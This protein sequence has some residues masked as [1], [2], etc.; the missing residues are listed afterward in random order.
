MRRS[1]SI[2]TISSKTTASDKS[3]KKKILLV[4][5]ESDITMSI[6]IALESYG[7]EVNSYNDPVMAL[8]CFR[9]HY[10]DL[11]MLDVKMPKIDGF[12]FY[13]EIKKIDSQAKICFNYSYRQK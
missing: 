3:G 1:L 9:P 5:D 2:P 12:E 6:S 4:D 10:Y 11:V 13:N 7:F 8:S